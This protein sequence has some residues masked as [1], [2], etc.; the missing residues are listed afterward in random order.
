VVNT[1]VFTATYKRDGEENNCISTS[2]FRSISRRNCIVAPVM[3][4]DATT[5]IKTMRFPFGLDRVNRTTAACRPEETTPSSVCCAAPFPSIVWTRRAFVNV[6]D[7]AE[8]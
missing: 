3:Q 6:L 2:L 1:D 4:A 5:Q 8:I 7:Y